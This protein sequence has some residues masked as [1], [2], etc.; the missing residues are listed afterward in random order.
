MTTGGLA[1]ELVDARPGEQEGVRR[2]RTIEV[3][4]LALPTVLLLERAWDRRWMTDD[5]FINLRVVRMI[6]DLHGPVF[7]NGERVE[8]T[9]SALWVWMLAVG[10]VVLPFRLEWV[11]ILLGLAC[12]VAGLALATFGA[13]RLHRLLGA[14]GPL[15]PVGAAVLAVISPVW[16]FSTSGLEGGLVFGWLG[17]TCWLLARWAGEDRRLAAASAVVLG[18]G[19]L[20]RPD[21]L[22]VSVIALAGVLVAQWEGDGARDRVRLLAWAAALPLAYELFR[23]GFFASL[24]PNTALTKGS[25]GSRWEVGFAYLRDFVQPYWLVVPLV[26]LLGAVL[27]PAL[28]RAQASGQRRVLVGLAALPV[29]GLLNGVYVVRVGGDY[30]HGRL[31]LPALFALV[32]PVAAVP[33][34]GLGTSAGDPAGTDG[35]GVLGRLRRLRGRDALATGA[36]VVTLLWS[37]VCLAWL[38]PDISPTVD[39]LFSSDARA[40]NVRQFGEHAVTAADQ[41]WGPDDDRSELDPHFDV[42]VEGRAIAVFAPGELPTPAYA[43]YGVGIAGYVYG[44]DVTIIDMLGLGDPVAAR[45]E[46]ARR[47][48]TGHEKPMPLPWLAARISSVPVDPA[49]LPDDVFVPLYESPPGRFDADTEAAREALDC[50]DLRALGKAVREPMGPQRFLSNLVSAPRY[51]FLSV[52]PDPNDAVDRFCGH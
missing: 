52:P 16:D 5:G 29:A 13:A 19:P 30:M 6:L 21:L 20:I 1:G 39:K 23:M 44:T 12:A 10:D 48:S 3:A 37:L 2:R 40:G 35:V 24:V 50:G 9:T 11:A 22:L 4:V 33:L 31:L 25:T 34:P 17:L 51:T 36:A 41:G 8:V 46:L 47:G 28:A 15:V 26:A 18:L 14:T 43:G 27:L 49:S 38:R 45:F 32:A 42:Y 7:N